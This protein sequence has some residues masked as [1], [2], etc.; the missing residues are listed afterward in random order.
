M[1]TKTFYGHR[2]SSFLL[3]LMWLLGHIKSY[4]R[5]FLF[6]S[7]QTDIME[8]S[9]G[10]HMPPPP[11]NGNYQQNV[12]YLEEWTGSAPWTK[13]TIIKLM[14]ESLVWTKCNV[15]SRKCWKRYA[16]WASQLFM[17]SENVGKWSFPAPVAHFLVFKLRKDAWLGSFYT[18]ANIDLLESMVSSWILILFECYTRSEVCAW[19][20]SQSNQIIYTDNGSQSSVCQIRYVSMKV[21][22]NLSRSQNSRVVLKGKQLPVNLITNVFPATYSKFTRCSDFVC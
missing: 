21:G 8:Q 13:K 22:C 18:E 16:R 1:C 11:L 2:R 17:Q 9:F 5:R 19:S 4:W 10:Q 20:F 14:L 7:L 15:A 6:C 3:M 12:S